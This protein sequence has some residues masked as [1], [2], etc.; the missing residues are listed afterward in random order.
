MMSLPDFLILVLSSLS[1]LL[2]L[3]K[4]FANFVDLFTEPTFGFTNSVVFLIS[5]SFIPVLIFLILLLLLA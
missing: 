2:S 4:R 1:F 5:V 3:A